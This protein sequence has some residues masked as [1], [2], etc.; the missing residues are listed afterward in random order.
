[1]PNDATLLEA[2]A[3]MFKALAHPSRLRMLQALRD[4]ERCVCDLQAVVGHDMSTVSK[5]LAVL[6]E[7]GIVTTEKRGTNIY[8]RL[9]LACL[10]VFLR[11][12][13]NAIRHRLTSQ[14]ARLDG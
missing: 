4:G 12:S 3:Q 6:R 5:H 8:Y 14:I 11:C 1:M 2:Q 7:A 10:D 9:S 13:E